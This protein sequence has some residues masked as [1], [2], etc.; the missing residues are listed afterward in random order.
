MREIA[1]YYDYSYNVMEAEGR[2]CLK[3]NISWHFMNVVMNEEQ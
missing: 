1:D 3:K 2:E